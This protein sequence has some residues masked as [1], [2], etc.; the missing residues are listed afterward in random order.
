MAL[1]GII[2]VHDEPGYVGEFERTLERIAEYDRRT[3][4]RW[5]QHAQQ[6]QACIRNRKLER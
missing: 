3:K 4:S 6:C 1:P 5:K 2:Y